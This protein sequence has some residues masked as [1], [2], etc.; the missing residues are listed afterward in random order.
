MLE[1]GEVRKVL[2]QE[3]KQYKRMRDKK[4]RR[5]QEKGGDAAWYD[6]NTETIVSLCWESRRQEEKSAKRL[7]LRRENIFQIRDNLG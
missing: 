1:E 6:Y 5:W 2:S 4:Q 3:E 7:R